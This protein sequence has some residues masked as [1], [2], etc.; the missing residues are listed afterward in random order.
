MIQP[1]MAEMGMMSHCCPIISR[2]CTRIHAST[3]CDY[4]VS[5][6]LQFGPKRTTKPPR[7]YFR[8]EKVNRG[9]VIEG[10]REPSWSLSR[11]RVPQPLEPSV[12]RKLPPYIYHVL[13][14]GNSS[15]LAAYDL[16][17]TPHH[18]Q[19]IYDREAPEQRPRIVEE[20]DKNIVVN[21]DNWVQYLGNQRYGHRTPGSCHLC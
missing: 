8:I 1:Q 15:I 9:L 18:L 10:F 12:S 5:P 16:G 17:A 2:Q 21:K 7:G 11:L 20:K 19:T 3:S 4:N 14:W 6:I 13:T